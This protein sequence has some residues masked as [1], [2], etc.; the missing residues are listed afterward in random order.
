MIYFRLFW[1]IAWRIKHTSLSSFN[2]HHHRNLP[3]GNRV[4]IKLNHS[5]FDF[6]ASAFFILTHSFLGI[7]ATFQVSYCNTQK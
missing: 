7:S 5:I 2:R 3:N 1:V 6:V 4:E